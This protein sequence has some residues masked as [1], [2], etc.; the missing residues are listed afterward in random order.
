MIPIACV[1]SLRIAWL[2][3]AHSDYMHASGAMR[4]VKFVASLQRAVETVPPEHVPNRQ[5]ASPRKP[6]GYCASQRVP[7]VGAMEGQ[8]GAGGLHRALT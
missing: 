4:Q 1:R 7:A 3:S 8:V 5:V 6:I 2:P